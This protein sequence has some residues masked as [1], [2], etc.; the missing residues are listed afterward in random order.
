MS[1]KQSLKTGF[2][3]GLASGVITTLGLIVGLE[4]GTNSKMVVVG[5]ILIIAIADSFSDALG[6]HIARESEN[7]HSFRS[8]WES[9]FAAFFSKFFIALTFLIPILLLSLNIAIIVSIVWGLSL[10]TVFSYY[11]ARMQKIKPLF[12]IGEHL[13]IAILVI[14]ITHFVGGYIKLIFQ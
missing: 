9:T 8:I 7:K 4:A 1:L 11:L 10:L 2:S 6:I 14:I 5:G 3:F 12:V 13:S